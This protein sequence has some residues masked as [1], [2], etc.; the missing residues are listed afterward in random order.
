MVVPAAHDELCPDRADNQRSIRLIP[1]AVA[2]VWTL[3]P[4]QLTSVL[5]VVQRMTSLSSLFVLGGMLLFVIGRTRA[6]SARPYAM[7]LMISGV[8]GGGVVGSLCKEIAVL[9]PLFALVVEIFFFDR[10]R[11]TN[12]NRGRLALFYAATVALPVAVAAVGLLFMSETI[13]AMYSIRDFTL[14]ERLLSESRILFFYVGLLIYPNVRHFGLFHDDIGLS[15]GFLE[16]WST[17]VCALG[18]LIL[19]VAALWAARRHSLWGLAVIWFLVGHVV[20]SSFLALEPVHEHRNYLPSLGLMLA[21][22]HYLVVFLERGASTGRLVTPIV[23]LLLLVVSFSTWTRAS[24]WED[25]L[26]LTTFMVRHHPQSYRSQMAL[27]F[28]RAHAGQDVGSVYQSYQRAAVINSKAVAPLVEMAKLV[29]VALLIGTTS[30]SGDGDDDIVVLEDDFS[31]SPHWLTRMQF[32]LNREITRRLNQYAIGS[33]ND[34]R[35]IQ[36]SAL[37]PGTYR[38]VCRS[39]TKWFGLA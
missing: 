8:V 36:P 20:E 38:S 35:I 18:W 22:I 25:R 19:A 15:T 23:S 34:T 30:E 12:L 28:A 10:K 9:T 2:L 3:H 27:A 39:R 14:E 4:I 24:L 29:Q 26:T 6:E 7:T 16:P 17:L 5:Y 31:T 21:A 11:F 1:L 37:R 32:V 13:L 33:N